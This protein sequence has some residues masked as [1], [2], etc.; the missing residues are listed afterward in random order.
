MHAQAQ[1]QVHQTTDAPGPEQYVRIESG[2]VKYHTLA[3]IAV[4][5]ISYTYLEP[6]A[7]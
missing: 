6:P 7:A 3:P 1:R 5:C 2:S 4:C